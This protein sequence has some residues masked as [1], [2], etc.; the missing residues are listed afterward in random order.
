MIKIFPA[1]AGDVGLIPG[2]G[3]RKWQPTP[4]FLP[5]KS[6]GQRSLAGYSPW[7]HKESD[8]TQWLS[9]HVHTHTHT[10]VCTILLLFSCLGIIF[11][12]SF[13]FLV[14]PFF[15]SSH[16]FSSP[17]VSSFSICH[18]AGLVVLNSFNFCLSGKLLIS[19]S[20]LKQSL[21]G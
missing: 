6:H 2:S 18:K 15:S 20:N 21:A 11:C 3:S 1:S 7:G 14:F 4:V 8:M 13:L 17:F 9:A 19:P 12:R 10:S 16:V 5:G